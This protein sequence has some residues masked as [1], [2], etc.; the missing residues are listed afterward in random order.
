[1]LWCFARSPSRSKGLT[2]TLAGIG[3]MGGFLGIV[4][5]GSAEAAPVSAVYTFGDSLSDTGNIAA[6]TFGTM[7]LPEFYYQG[8]FSNGPVWVDH[9]AAAFGTE[10]KASLLGG[11][12]HA[13][14]GATTGGTVPPGVTFQ[15]LDFLSKVPTT[16]AD[17]NALYIVYGGGNDVRNELT[18]NLPG[19]TLAA[20][21]TA[22]VSQAVTNLAL[23][24]ARHIMVPNLSDLALTPEAIMAGGEFA[25]RATSLS[26]AFNTALTS[27]MVGLEAVLPVDLIPLDV[28]SLFNDVAANPGNYGLTNVNTPCFSGAVDRPGTV[29]SNPDEYLFWDSLHPTAAAH[30][31]L[32]DYA[33][34]ALR[35][36]GVGGSDGDPTDVPEPATLVLVAGGLLGMGLLRR[37]QSSVPA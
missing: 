14:G 21:A 29:C 3:L 7:P 22:N 30:R 31:I 23:A 5:A 34:A 19:E 12:N 24:G 27:V 6:A 26:A 18:S 1:M 13:F 36:S 4:A 25:E 35:G 33:L 8:R 2:A 28:R 15:T 11:T 16:G 20:A 10:S 37:R 9:V 32:A 17:P